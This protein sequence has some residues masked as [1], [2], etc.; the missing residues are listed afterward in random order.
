MH[1]HHRRSNQFE[2]DDAR[3]NVNNEVCC[4]KMAGVKSTT[5]DA[6]QRSK[7]ATR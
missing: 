6:T 7:I 5:D 4:G 1:S 2:I 3:R